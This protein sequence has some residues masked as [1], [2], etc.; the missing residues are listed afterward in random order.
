MAD[1]AIVYASVHHGNTKKLLE[2]ISQKCD[3][4]LFDVLGKD[5][6]DRVDF[7]KYEAVGFASGIYMSKFHKSLIG[8][9]D[10]G[11]ALPKKTFVMYT[12]GSGSDKYGHSLIERLSQLGTEVLGMYH[13]KGYDTFALFKLVGGIAKGHPNQNEI[14]LGVKFIKNI[15]CK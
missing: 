12:S 13:C 1:I 8:F 15:A 5:C 10:K 14:D 9:L 2:G 6:I 7:S 11:V 3:I 4:D